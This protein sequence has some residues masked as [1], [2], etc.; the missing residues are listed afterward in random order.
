MNK[1]ALLFLMAVP[2]FAQTAQTVSGV[3]TP[4]S[5]LIVVAASNSINKASANY[6]ATGTNDQTTINTAINAC[7]ATLPASAGPA[8]CT[9]VLQP[10]V[11]NVSASV[12]IDTDDV[13]LTGEGHCMWGGYNGPWSGTGSPTGAIGTGCSQLKATTTGFPLVE[14]AH[15]NAAGTAAGDTNRHRG[16]KISQLYLVGSSYGNHGVVT[17]GNGG[18]CNTSYTYGGYTITGCP[19]DNVEI[20]DNVIQRTDLGIGVALDAPNIHGNSIQDNNGTAE[21]ICGSVARVHDELLWDNNGTQLIAC[22]V[23]GTYTNSTLGDTNGDAIHFYVSNQTASGNVFAGIV[24]SAAYIDGVGGITFSGNTIDYTSD[25]G[26]F[27]VNGKL[28][29]SADAVHIT[30]TG[31]GN[32]IIGNTFN[33]GVNE[34]G[35]AIND[36][37]SSDTVT[38]NTAK[39]TWRFGLGGGPCS[40]GCGNPISSVTAS[41]PIVATATGSVVNLT[42]PTCGT[43]GGTPGLVQIAQTVLAS[44]AAT[45]T[46]SS[47]PGTYSNLQLV[48]NGQT[49]NTSADDVLCRFNSDTG[50]NYDWNYFFFNTVTGNGTNQAQTSAHCANV[51]SNSTSATSPGGASI[52]IQNYAGTTF[53]KILTAYNT[54]YTG[55]AMSSTLFSGRWRSTS[56]ITSITLATASGSNF[57]AGT[58]ATLYGL[59]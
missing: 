6:V 30:A 39:G 8:Q 5:V 16:I 48:I 17:I 19:D 38:S 7:P 27:N 46:F 42:C 49:A 37:G 40:A 51:A 52:D 26:G 58:V 59:Q 18:T 20:S 24:G 54:A 14:I 3:T 57:S 31:S 25:I 23:G 15:S 13:T 2:A 44:P 47:I 35:Y 28:P 41:T 50:A 10:G 21:M 9:V 53:Y 43:S 56:A 55:S 1:A 45:I 32:T 22:S 29:T 11:Y 34:T 33:S 12:V 36:L 4:N